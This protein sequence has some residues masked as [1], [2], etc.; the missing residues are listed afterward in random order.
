M[1]HYKEGVPVVDSHG[2][3]LKLGAYSVRNI[4]NFFLPFRDSGFEVKEPS[5]W[6]EVDLFQEVADLGALDQ[7]QTAS[8]AAYA[9]ARAVELL[10][11]LNAQKADLQPDVL[12]ARVSG[13]QD[14]GC[15]I[16]DAVYGAFQQAKSPGYGLICGGF[17]E[18]GAAIQKRLPV[19]AGL[20][21]GPD[22]SKT[23]PD[24]FLKLPNS[25]HGATA[26]LIGGV[27]KVGTEWYLKGQ[28]TW[29][30]KFGDGGFVYLHRSLVVRPVGAYALTQDLPKKVEKLTLQEAQ[31]FLDTP[32]KI[33][34]KVSETKETDVKTLEGNTVKL[35]ETVEPAKTEPPAVA[36]EINARVDAVTE[37]V[38]KAPPIELPTPT[39]AEA[40]PK[41][42]QQT[43]GKK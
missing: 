20:M 36:Q 28:M 37:Q 39:P 22:I 14:S 7:G 38:K 9:S 35:K 21:V 18:I 1:H 34:D 16:E 2:R 12:Y 42:G 3:T 33:V 10:L 5:D 19:V 6:T 43:Q 17:N 31:A 25:T 11:R 32:I 26:V 15:L 41:T 30:S 40:K 23:G 4:A 24:G 27:K 13:G 29:G 8:S